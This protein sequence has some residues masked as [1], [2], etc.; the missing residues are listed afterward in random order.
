MVMD[1]ELCVGKISLELFAIVT[2]LNKKLRLKMASFAFGKVV[3]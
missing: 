3:N 2:E 1:G